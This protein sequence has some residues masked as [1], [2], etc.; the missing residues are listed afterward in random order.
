MTKTNIT[1]AS[2]TLGPEI[3]PNSIYLVDFSKL[4]SVNDLIMI[5]STMGISFPSNHPHINLL[6]PFLNLDNPIPIP[7]NQQQ[8]IK[9]ELNLPKLKKL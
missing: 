1:L 4:T 2:T 9:T 8:P 6:K 7:N 5:L 3:K